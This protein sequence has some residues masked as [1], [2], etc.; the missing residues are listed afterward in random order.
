MTSSKLASLHGFHCMALLALLLF[1][2]PTTVQADKKK[3]TATPVAKKTTATPVAKKTTAA[4][5]AKKENTIKASVSLTDEAVTQLNANPSLKSQ[6]KGLRA[7]IYTFDPNVGKGELVTFLEVKSS[8]QTVFKRNSPTLVFEFPQGQSAE[9]IAANSSLIMQ[10]E[11]LLD[12]SGGYESISVVSEKGT[13]E[14]SIANQPFGA[15]S[16]KPFQSDL[17]KEKINNDA[18]PLSF[19]LRL[20]AAPSPS[21]V[22]HLEIKVTVGRVKGKEIDIKLNGSPFCK[23]PS[24][25]QSISLEAGQTDHIEDC[26]KNSR[27]L[28]FEATSED[29]SEQFVIVAGVP[30]DGKLPLNVNVIQRKPLQLELDVSTEKRKLFWKNWPEGQPLKITIGQEQRVHEI[31]SANAI[32]SIRPTSLRLF[33]D[34]LNPSAIEAIYAEHLDEL[35]KLQAL[36]ESL[37]K[38]YPEARGGG[39][40]TSHDYFQIV[41]TVVEATVYGRVTLVIKLNLKSGLI[42]DPSTEDLQDN[43]V[44]EMGAKCTSVSLNGGET[45]FQKMA[46]NRYVL[47]KPDALGSGDWL[48]YKFTFKQSE[49]SDAL[50]VPVQRSSIPR[51]PSSDPVLIEVWD[52]LKNIKVRPKFKLT[53]DLTSFGAGAEP[54]KVESDFSAPVEMASLLAEASFHTWSNRQAIKAP[55][56]GIGTQSFVLHVNQNLA[57]HDPH[58]NERLGFLDLWSAT[59]ARTL[60]PA[61]SDE[62]VGTVPAEF[63]KRARSSTPD[64]AISGTLLPAPLKKATTPSVVPAG[65]IILMENYMPWTISGTRGAIWAAV[66]KVMADAQFKASPPQRTILGVADEGY[67]QIKGEEMKAGETYQKYMTILDTKPTQGSRFTETRGADGWE[68]LLSAPSQ[69]DLPSNRILDTM[70]RECDK[71]KVFIITPGLGK[72]LTAGDMSGPSG[73]TKFDPEYILICPTD[74]SGSQP[75]N[76]HFIPVSDSETLSRDNTDLITQKIKDIILEKTTTH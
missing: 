27:T 35:N 22:S 33:I 49:K 15:D 54:R 62:W 75:G 45:A 32:R 43:H 53:S 9:R 36:V 37:K 21:R 59:L 34:K 30:A 61:P 18:F 4:P 1:Q 73:S 38:W 28:A 24:D 55:E 23:W 65:V 44:I 52:H 46:E 71:W 20:S 13:I 39:D 26:L 68:K 11:I 31:A 25:K 70:L 42:F 74:S 63:I 69:T 3:T 67:E 7:A 2:I 10:P 60:L 12:K 51:E 66:K 40:N 14:A 48:L 16:K 19:D 50:W 76:S 72:K 58:K 41:P 47:E 29:S 64:P 57:V 8:L 5:A 6:I 17:L 56:S